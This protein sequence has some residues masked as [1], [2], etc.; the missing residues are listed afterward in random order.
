M[1]YLLVLL[2]LL[3]AVPAALILTDDRK[4][5]KVGYESAREE[6][7][8]KLRKHEQHIRELDGDYEFQKYR[9][10]YIRRSKQLCDY[11]RTQDVKFYEGN[12]DHAVAYVKGFASWLP[13]SGIYINPAFLSQLQSG[14]VMTQQV[15][16]NELSHMAFWAEDAP[17]GNW[18]DL[19]RAKLADYSD[20]YDA[21]I[22]F[23]DRQEYLD[24][25][26]LGKSLDFTNRIR[27][28]KSSWQ[29]LINPFFR[30]PKVAL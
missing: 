12:E 17:V 27:M 20:W 6:M 11:I 13:R 18:E 8:R 4:E 1:K 14:D 7:I 19:P 25:I 30:A 29:E 9:V 3:V 10:N 2:A 16:L 23:G 22:M 24:K 28:I 26:I 15:I 21:L 5:V